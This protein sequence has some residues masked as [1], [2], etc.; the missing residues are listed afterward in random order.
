MKPFPNFFNELQCICAQKSTKPAYVFYDLE[1]SGLSPAHD[2]ILQFAAIFTDRDFNTLK[3][4]DIRIKLRPDVVP[5]PEALYVTQTSPEFLLHGT[6]DN[7]A[8]NEHDAMNFIYEIL[9]YPN[10]ISIGY[11]NFHFD[12]EFIRFKN[13]Q[14]QLPPYTHEWANHCHKLDVYPIVMLAHQFFPKTLKWPQINGKLS[15]KLEHM[16]RENNVSTGISH[17]ALVD[18]QDTINLTKLLAN[19][20]ALWKLANMLLTKS[21]DKD[22]ITNSP[23]ALF[24]N[25]TKYQ[26]GFIIDQ[27]ANSAPIPVISLGQQNNQKNRI[28]F[29]RLDKLSLQNT[30]VE[31]AVSEHLFISKKYGE[32]PFYFPFDNKHCQNKID[33]QSLNIAQSNINLL[34]QNSFVLNR[35]L[36]AA[37]NMTFPLREN[38]DSN[39]CLYSNGFPNQETANLLEKFRF[40]DKNRKLEAALKINDQHQKALAIRTLGNNYPSLLQPSAN[41]SKATSANKEI[42]RNQYKHYMQMVIQ[43]NTILDNHQTPKLTFS[44]AISKANTMLE[45]A[46][47]ENNPDKVIFMSKIIAWYH[48]RAQALKNDFSNTVNIARHTIFNTAPKISGTRRDRE[49]TTQNEKQKIAP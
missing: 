11:N 25:K 43:G 5:S 29:L 34:K 1:T 36:Q 47:K 3:S 21:S 42:A 30:S 22:Q 37:Q 35:F 32:L 10:T 2:Q 12:N 20:D 14:N 44:S 16:V 41:D 4:I 7:P 24:I 23:T 15:L 13:Y 26:L 46:K 33:Q 48:S 38:I 9:N 45:N 19:D 49:E 18:V 17:D 27:F 40:A 6:P 8:I 31:Q 39:A 28:S